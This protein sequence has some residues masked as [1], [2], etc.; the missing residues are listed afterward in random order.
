MQQK[1]PRRVTSA[2]INILERYFKLYTPLTV[3]LRY[4]HQFQLA[5]KSA[6]KKY[7]QFPVYKYKSSFDYV[8]TSQYRMYIRCINPINTGPFGGSS[9]PGWGGC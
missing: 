9:V 1:P 2:A 5:I 3:Y 7:P 8:G 4:I 6:F